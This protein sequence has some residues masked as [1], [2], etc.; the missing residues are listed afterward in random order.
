MEDSQALTFLDFLRLAESSGTRDVKLDALRRAG[1]MARRLIRETL[2]PY[3]VFNVK[4]IAL[5]TAFASADADD[6]TAFLALLDDLHARRV[7]GNAARAAV[8]KTLARYTRETAEALCRVLSKDLRC[9]ILATTVNK[10]Y[11]GLIPTFSCMLAEKLDPSQPIAFPVLASS[12]LD[13]TRALAFVGPEGCVYY[14]RSGKP[15]SH[16]DGLFDAELQAL[17]QRVGQPFVLD[18]EVMG[19]SFQETLNAKAED[20]AAARAR[21]RFNA[22]DL[23][24]RAEWDARRSLKPQLERQRD[25]DALLD[26]AGCV[27]ILPVR[28]RVV[29]NHDELMEFYRETLELGYEGLILKDVD[30]GYAFERSRAWK[31]FKPTITVDLKV[32]GFYEGREGSKYVGT[33]GGIDVEGRDENGTFIRASVGSGFSDA[34]RDEIWKNRETYL[35]MTVEIE[36][37]EITVTDEDAP[38]SLRFP[39]FKRFRDDK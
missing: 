17:L 19:S 4:R 15:A 14:S 25:L 22:F 35:G 34:Q 13:G 20:N 9:G 36:C 5:P 11:P 8:T 23:L 1:E 16:L 18:G 39:V 37:Q 21:L 29:S 6:G 2:D 31:K 33:L 32:T 3:R 26:A 12:K 10:V 28:Y 27:K 38:R 24:T 7:T 30:A